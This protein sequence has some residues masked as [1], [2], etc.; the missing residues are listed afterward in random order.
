VRVTAITVPQLR[1]LIAAFGFT[2]FV[3]KKS[4]SK[5]PLIRRRD[6]D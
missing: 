2:I 4:A 5:I 1:V 3:L 6:A